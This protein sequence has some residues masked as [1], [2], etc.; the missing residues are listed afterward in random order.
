MLT[1][2]PTGES[3]KYRLL[4]RGNAGRGVPDTR[5]PFRRM[6]FAQFATRHALS[7]CCEHRQLTVLLSR[8]VLGFA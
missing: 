5:D 3:A 6:Q 7:H 1:L 4:L 2:R 8:P